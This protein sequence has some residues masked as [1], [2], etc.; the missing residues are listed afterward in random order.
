M[1]LPPMSLSEHH[2]RTRPT[3]WLFCSPHPFPCLC[4]L[5]AFHIWMPFPWSSPHWPP[6]TWPLPPHLTPLHTIAWRLHHLAL[7]PFKDKYN[8]FLPPCYV[9]RAPLHPPRTQKIFFSYQ[10]EVCPAQ[11]SKVLARQV[12]C[13]PALGGGALLGT[14]WCVSNP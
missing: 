11:P 4:S 7:S 1:Y 10:S 5:S 3:L 6:E 8:G 9:R 12:T 2:P 13:L 14:W